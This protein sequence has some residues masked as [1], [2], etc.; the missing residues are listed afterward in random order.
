MLVKVSAQLMSEFDIPG[1]SQTDSNCGR[2][3]WVAMLSTTVL[4]AA[5]AGPLAG[6][7]SNVEPRRTT[8]GDIVN[9]RMNPACDLF[10]LELRART[11]P[12]E[13]CT[14][15]LGAKIDKCSP[16]CGLYLYWV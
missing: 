16:F 4:L 8:S 1:C 6:V 12:R 9:V 13:V 7:I 5:I 11:A 14:G 10:S 2:V 3:V 15:S